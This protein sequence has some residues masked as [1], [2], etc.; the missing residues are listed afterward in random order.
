MAVK[1]FSELFQ[2]SQS[3]Q[4][5]DILHNFHPRVSNAM[6]I[7]TKEISVSE[8]TQA[9]F[10]ISNESAPGPYGLTGFFLKHTD[11]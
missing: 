8:I 1:Y 6:N 2:T 10:S 11:I 4:T 7:V 5:G 3:H 9:V